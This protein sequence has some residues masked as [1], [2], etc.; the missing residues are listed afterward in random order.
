M[1]YQEFTRKAEKLLFSSEYDALQKALTIKKPNL[2]R[3]LGVANRETRISR[4]L[5]WLLNPRANHTFGDLF[6]KEF[7][8][9]SLRADVGYKSILTPVEI[10]LLD[11]SNALIKTEYTFPN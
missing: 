3:I 11:L 10:S 2:W 9:Q 8:V 4:F 6:L 7:L 1:E 5:A